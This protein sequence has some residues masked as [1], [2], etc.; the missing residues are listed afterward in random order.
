MIPRRFRVAARRRELADTVTLGLEP[1]DGEP[2]QFS[3]GQ[4]D[5]LYAFGVGEAAISFSG[6][7]DGRVEHTVRAVG[8][9]TRALCA[10]RRGD[11]LG[12]RG[13]FGAG[14]DVES[15]EGADV[16]IVAGGLGLAPLRPAV[17]ALLARRERYGRIAVIIGARSPSALLFRRDLAAWSARADVD[18][19]VTVDAAGRDWRGDVGLVTELIP[20]AP[21]DPADTIALICGPEI[22]MRF[23]AAALLERGVSPSA[24]RI[25]MERN[26]KCAIGHCGHCQFGPDFV[27]SDGPVLAFDRVAPL[28]TLREV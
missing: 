25:S 15:A 12:V 3:P 10:T 16:V 27:C 28:L 5:M 6:A 1:L 4:F 2:P 26:M 19:A 18:V 24:I 17:Q 14:W 20:R 13:P 11:V 21:F 8:A 7:G 23:A 9:V 22:M